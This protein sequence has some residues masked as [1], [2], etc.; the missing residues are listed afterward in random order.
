MLIIVDL[1]HIMN[2]VQSNLDVDLS[3]KTRQREHVEARALYFK[4]CRDFTSKSFY[5][6]G[7]SLNKNHA[8][9]IHAVNNV[10]PMAEMYNKRLKHLYN[11][12]EKSASSYTE[13]KVED[14]DPYQE[15]VK[16]NSEIMRL[17]LEIQR[18][19]DVMD[20]ESSM[21]EGL[22]QDEI[23]AIIEKISV[24]KKVIE[25]QRHMK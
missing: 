25:A 7:K 22:D 10:Y 21:F 17:N 23:D 4:L 18:L 1:K 9:V 8:T 11:V 13:G 19:K 20:A 14:K 6:I 24:F 3:V 12:F 5:D 2:F 16:L 15:N